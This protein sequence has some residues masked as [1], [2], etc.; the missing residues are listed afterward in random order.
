MVH[1]HS[2]KL[3]LSHS[4]SVAV[5]FSIPL[6]PLISREVNWSVRYSRLKL[7]AA[8]SAAAAATAAASGSQSQFALP[9]SPP[10]LPSS[11]PSLSRSLTRFGLEA[12][13]AAL[14]VKQPA[15]DA[16]E[17]DW[18][19]KICVF[20]DL[21]NPPRLPDSLTYTLGRP[22]NRDVLFSFLSEVPVT[23]WAAQ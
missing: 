17:A 3:S 1:F 16:G 8:A 18:S 13:A 10:S 12:L 6:F 11:P 23:N 15:A 21:T 20:Y 9:S 4:N 22:L 14:D 7:K 5:F 19:G 2:L